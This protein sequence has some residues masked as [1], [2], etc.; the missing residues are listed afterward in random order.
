MSN[1]FEAVME[2]F[3]EPGEPGAAVGVRH[4]DRPP[5]V[6]GFG[7]AD[8][9]WG[10]AITHDTV[11]RIGSITKQFT[12]AAIMLL[13]EEGRLDLDDAIQ[14]V[15]PDYPAQGRAITIRRLLNHT[16]GIKNYTALPDFGA[17]MRTDMTLAELIGVFKDLPPNFAPGERFAY[18]NSGYALLGAVIEARSGMPYRTFLEERFFAPLGLEQTRYLDDEPIV[19]KRARGYDRGAGGVQNARTM[20]MTLP[21][22]AGALGSTVV[23]L[24]TWERALRTGQVVSPAS[25]GAMTEPARLNG[26]ALS[27]YGFGLIGANYRNHAATTH[28]GGI[29][30]FVTVMTH[31]EDDDLTVVVLSNLTSFPVERAHLALARRALDLPDVAARPR[32]AVSTDDLAR[33]AGVFRL[34]VGPLSVAAGDGGLSV[35]FPRPNSR[36]EPCSETEFELAGDPETTLTFGDPGEGGYRQVTVKGPLMSF[37]GERAAAES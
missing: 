25:Y 1:K 31:F 34:S 10:A 18:S 2:A 36:Y 29:N 26:G 35:S 27:E 12:A 20:S 9:E 30:G 37:P 28:S 5:Y 4:G 7:L 19:A 23:D 16:A 17:L 6:A 3:V 24:L 32:V 33:C 22:A 14:S 21:H 11:F 15:L 8:V 13:V